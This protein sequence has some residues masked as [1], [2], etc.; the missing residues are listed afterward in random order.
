MPLGV[1][2]TVQEA[3]ESW[4][5]C[6]ACTADVGPAAFGVGQLLSEGAA[7]SLLSEYPSVSR[8]R[9]ST[10]PLTF[11]TSSSSFF[12]TPSFELRASKMARRPRE[13]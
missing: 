7:A 5:K 11:C 9:A 2:W 1:R 6:T 12:S 13:D 3:F 10:F 8:R 4:Q